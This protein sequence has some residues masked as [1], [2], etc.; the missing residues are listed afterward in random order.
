MVIIK[1]KALLQQKHFLKEIRMF[2]DLKT[3]TNK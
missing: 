1:L 2:K 3:N